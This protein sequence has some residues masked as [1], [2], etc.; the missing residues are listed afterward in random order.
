MTRAADRGLWCA[1]GQRGE[2]ERVDVAKRWACKRC[3]LPAV[4]HWS[5][6]PEVQASP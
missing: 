6:R 5:A 3:G 1:D 4:D 2:F